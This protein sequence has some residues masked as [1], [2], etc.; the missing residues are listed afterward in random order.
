MRFSQTELKLLREVAEGK[1]RISKIA[2]ALKKSSK[3]ISRAAA[4][5]ESSSILERSRGRLRLTQN[6][7]TNLLLQLLTYHPN[8]SKLLAG[9]GIPV[10]TA[11]LKPS[12]PSKAKT[13]VRKSATYLKIREA[14]RISALKKEGKTYVI[15][16][17]LWP[18]LAEF[19]ESARSFEENTDARVP[20]GAVIY[21]RSKDYVLFSTRT[22]LD[23]ALTAFSAYGKYGIRLFLPVNYYILPKQTLSKEDVFIHS[24]GVAEKDPSVRNIIFIALFYLKHRDSLRRIRHP[25]LVNISKVLGGESVPGYPSPEE[26]KD[27]AQV[28]GIKVR[29]VP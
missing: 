19:L 17:G 7:H 6:T 10:L 26:I 12:V 21:A 29:S 13:G 24:L 20:P 16:K 5:L 3:Q 25:I 9:S 8:L 22:A 14:F 18:T 11:F 28:Y 1:E 2:T 4:R 15:N 23:A 27:K